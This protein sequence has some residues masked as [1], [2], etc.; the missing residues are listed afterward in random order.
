MKRV[1]TNQKE[2]VAAWVAERMVG[3]AVWGGGY[4][5]LGV[6]QDGNL[7]GGVVVDEYVKDVRC[8]MHCAGDGKQWLSR[9]F[10]F[11]VFDY[12]FRQLGCRLIV[13]PVNSENTRSVKF[14]SDIGFVEKCRIK[15]GS[16]EGDL[17]IFV[18]RR[19]DCRWLSLKKELQ[20]G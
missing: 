10:L 19:E 20:H 14:I 18:M 15:D 8:S 1:I 2:R 3:G 7:I 4:E 16:P 9:K 12:A 5:A 17:I 11:A 6:E 13:S